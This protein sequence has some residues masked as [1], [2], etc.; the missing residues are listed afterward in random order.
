MLLSLPIREMHVN[1]TA[2]QYS[3]LIWMAATKNTQKI[4]SIDKNT[5]NLV[6]HMI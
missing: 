6:H 3:L 4:T 2:R 1:S 5:V